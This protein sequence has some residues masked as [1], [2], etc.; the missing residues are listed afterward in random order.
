MSPIAKLF[1]IL[2]VI[3]AGVF[4]GF[5]AHTLNTE[6]SFKERLEKE[7]AAHKVDKDAL[8]ADKSKLAAEKAE[9][10]KARDAMQGERDS[11]KAEIDRLKGQVSDQE[12]SN[13]EM[14]GSVDKISKSIDQLVADNKQLN[15]SRDKA[16]A[17][18]R[19]A[20]KAR[21]DANTA[22][23]AAEAKAGDLDTKLHTSDNK[24]ADLEKANV[25]LTKDKDSLNTS[26]ES[27]SAYT[28]VKLSDFVNVPQ[29]EGKVLDVAMQ[30]EP[31]LVSINKGTDDGVKQGFTFELY[32]GKTY[33]G[34][35]RV[36]YVHKSSCSALLVRSVAG[37]K[38]KQGDS[39]STRL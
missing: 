21:D 29:I 32:D 18:Q 3:L 27:L 4:L 13:N 10:E 7:T 19:E 1:T 22:R 16:S 23:A 38:I 8:G 30:L 17:A 33:K 15:D 24:I 20:E 12:R 2:N 28:N 26:L 34:Q 14:R 6:A 36:E 5:A 31:G 35:A 9:L 39:A 37:Q 25:Q 11:A